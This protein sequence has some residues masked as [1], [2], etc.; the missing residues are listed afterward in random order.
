MTFADPDNVQ[1]VL[2]AKPH[3]LDSKTVSVFDLSSH[4]LFGF[5][6]RS[7]TEW[8]STQSGVA[9]RCTLFNTMLPLALLPD[10]KLEECRLFAPHDNENLLS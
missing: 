1:D 9:C 3:I 7:G 6:P 2:N 8:E 4:F 10:G 5:R